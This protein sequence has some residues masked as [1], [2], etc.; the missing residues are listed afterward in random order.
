MAT[1]LSRFSGV[2]ATLPTVYTNAF[3]VSSYTGGLVESSDVLP[4]WIQ[5]ARDEIDRHTG[6]CFRAAERTDRLDGTGLDILF[7]TCFP[8]LEILAIEIDGVLFDAP[9]A[10][11]LKK[12]KANLRTGSLLRKDGRPWPEGFENIE[13]RYL[14][15]FRATPPVVQKL[16]T[17]LV[18][19]TALQAKHG[20]TVDNERIGNFSVSRSFKR[21]DDELDRAWS[22]LGFRRDIGFV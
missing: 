16:A 12:V 3:L 11:R 13:V 15:G 18:A 10:G 7:L 2:I 5:Q 22:A 8:V 4:E 19:K 6:M 17:L 20:P 21:I 1:L 9:V 14:F